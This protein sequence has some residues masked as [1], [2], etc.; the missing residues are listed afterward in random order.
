MDKFNCFGENYFCIEIKRKQ[1]SFLY[2]NRS[3]P[4]FYRR[5]TLNE[6]KIKENSVDFK[7]KIKELFLNDVTTNLIKTHIKIWKFLSHSTKGSPKHFILMNNSI[8]IRLFCLFNHVWSLQNLD[9]S[10]LC[11][12]EI[13]KNNLFSLMC[14]S[15]EN[16]I[17]IWTRENFLFNFSP[18]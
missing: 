16:W 14:F 7:K 4:K 9:S 15:I 18:S 1:F 11:R 17:V 13:Y 3:F 5:Q 10:R 12:P 2:S 8:T 6:R